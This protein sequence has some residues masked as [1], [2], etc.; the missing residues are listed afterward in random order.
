MTQEEVNS[1]VIYNDATWGNNGKDIVPSRLYQAF[2]VE[3]PW[4]GD[5]E[6]TWYTFDPGLFS[7][8]EGEKSTIVIDPA[9]ENYEANKYGQAKHL[10]V[11]KVTV[12][13]SK[14]LK[15]TNPNAIVVIDGKNYD[16]NKLN[17][18]LELYMDRDH[19]ISIHWSEKLVETF[20]V[21]KL[22]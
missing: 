10:E 9:Y 14:A 13:V 2:R 7:G 1:V 5:D 15:A 17:Q 12:T 19:R 18:A 20:R 3:G 8:K 21:I 11:V 22:K 6:S 4:L 16:L